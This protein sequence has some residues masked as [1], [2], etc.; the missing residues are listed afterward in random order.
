MARNA[1]TAASARDS[2]TYPSTAFN[3]TTLKIAMASY[4]SADSRS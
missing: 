4:G 2:C 3:S 1:A